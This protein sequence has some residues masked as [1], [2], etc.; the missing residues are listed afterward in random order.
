MATLA[1]GTRRQMADESEQAIHGEREDGVGGHGHRRG[2]RGV[3]GT[4][5]VGRAERR[6]TRK[7]GTDRL[8][9]AVSPHGYGGGWADSS[10][11]RSKR[12]SRT[13]ARGCRGDHRRSR[14]HRF[15]SVYVRRI[16]RLRNKSRLLYAGHASSQT[17][18]RR[19]RVERQLARGVR[20]ALR[21]RHDSKRSLKFEYAS[22]RTRV[23]VH[24][25]RLR[26]QG[27]LCSKFTR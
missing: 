3:D 25:S 19:R 22:G 10:G 24:R 9:L 5:R 16:I 8:V 20:A 21:V 11:V 17:G 7:R 6:E 14:D 26:V 23:G 12:R 4:R 18:R 27:D 13:H 2:A 15:Q 1:S